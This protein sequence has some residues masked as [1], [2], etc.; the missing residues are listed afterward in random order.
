M[1]AP[2]HRTPATDAVKCLHSFLSE[3][4]KEMSDERIIAALR[5]EGIDPAKSVT[6]IKQMIKQANNRSRLAEIRSALESKIE[7]VSGVPHKIQRIADDLT[8]EIAALVRRIS[9]TQ[10]EAAAVFYRKLEQSRPEDLESLLADLRELA[11]EGDPG[12]DQNRS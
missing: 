3:E 4:Q 9:E 10:P 11:E 1:K 2:K 8:G 12:E 6:Q 7:S 5:G